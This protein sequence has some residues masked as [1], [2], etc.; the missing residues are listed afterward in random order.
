MA[1]RIVAFSSACRAAAFRL[2]SSASCLEV[3]EASI[4]DP[5]PTRV[6]TSTTVS[7]AICAGKHTLCLQTN[8]AQSIS[9]IPNFPKDPS[10]SGLALFGKLGSGKW[11]E[12]HISQF[13]NRPQPIWL[14]TQMIPAQMAQDYFGNWEIGKWLEVQISQINN[15]P[16][17]P[18]PSRSAL[19]GKMGN[20][21]RYILP[22]SPFPK[23]PQPVW[24]SIVCE[25]WKQAK[26]TDFP[27][28]QMI[29]AQMAQDYFGNWEIGKWLE[30]QISQFNNFPKDPSPSGSALFGKLGNG[31]VV[32]GT[33]FRIS[34]FPKTTAQMGQHD[35][36]NWEIGKWLEV[37]ISQ[38]KNFPKDPAQM[39][40]H[41]LGNWEIGNP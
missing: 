37:H 4:S 34:Q 15:F 8:L 36:G 5:T 35:L 29:P 11:L 3:H 18:S 25:I 9:N 20:G 40:Q 13:P 33:Y 7:S 12:V 28:S 38:F 30:V 6:S 19:F 17:D 24:L 26:D 1:R 31:E 41:Y 2:S 21:Y 23:R 27:I 22:N 32:T 14:S 10:P 39:A 16:K